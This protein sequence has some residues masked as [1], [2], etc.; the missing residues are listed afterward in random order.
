MPETGTKN[1]YIFLI[2]NYSIT[3]SKD[4]P[5][6][7][8]IMHIPYSPCTKR[9]PSKHRRTGRIFCLWLQFPYVETQCPAIGQLWA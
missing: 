7:F 1:K 5:P 2:T 9:A 3:G 6:H 4:P 8:I